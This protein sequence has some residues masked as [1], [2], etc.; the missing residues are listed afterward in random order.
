MCVDKDPF[1]EYL[2]EP[3]PDKAHK[4]YIW[5]TALANIPQTDLYL[6]TS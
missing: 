1:E 4:G 3:D 6:H 5:N 2:R